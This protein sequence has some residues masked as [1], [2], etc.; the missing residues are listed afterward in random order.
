MVK[1]KRQLRS[2]E[3]LPAWCKLFSSIS[4]SSVVVELLSNSILL[5]LWAKVSLYK[6]LPHFLQFGLFSETSRKSKEAYAKYKNSQG[7]E[8]LKQ[9]MVNAKRQPRSAQRRA[10]TSLFYDDVL[11]FCQLKFFC[12]EITLVTVSKQVCKIWPPSF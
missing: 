2:M 11:Y 1:A 3:A 8:N 6:S 7:D 5:R 12:V 10:Y 9:K 4:I